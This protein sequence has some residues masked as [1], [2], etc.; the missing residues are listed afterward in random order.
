VYEIVRLTA[1]FSE[2][3]LLKDGRLMRKLLLMTGTAI[4]VLLV[5]ACGG[6]GPMDPS[7]TMGPGMGGDN[8]RV[9]AVDTTAR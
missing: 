3:E 7:Q 6:N 4:T 1:L 9:A 8:M 5:G 2:C